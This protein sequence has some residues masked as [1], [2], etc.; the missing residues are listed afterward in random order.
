MSKYVFTSLILLPSILLGGILE[1]EVK[2]SL[3]EAGFRKIEGYDAIVLP[4]HGTTSTIGAPELPRAALHLSLPPGATVTAVEIL[5]CESEMLPGT[6]DV[7]PAQPLIPTSHVELYHK[8]VPQDPTIYSSS[9]PYPDRIIECAGTGTMSGYRIAGLLVHPFQYVP[10]EGKLVFHR[11]IRFRVSYNTDTGNAKRL[12]LKKI[13]LFL[14]DVRSLVINPDD[15]ESFKPPARRPGEKAY[16]STSL[17]PG[18]WDYVIIAASAA[19]SGVLDPVRAWKHKK[20]V[21]AKTVLRDFIYANYSGTN[22]AKVKSFVADAEATW[23][24]SWF[25]VAG[26]VDVIPIKK[27]STGGSIQGEPIPSDHYYAD[28]DPLAGTQPDYEDVWLSRASIETLKECSTFVKKTLGYEKNPSFGYTQTLAYFPSCTLASTNLGHSADTIA[29]ITPSP[30]WLD[31]IRQEW[32]GYLS[33]SEI[34]QAFN[35][36]IYFCHISAHGG[37]E[38]WGHSQVCGKHLIANVDALTN[39]PNLFILNAMCCFIGCLD[40]GSGDC[41]TEHMANNPN[42]G[43]AGIIGN[44]RYGWTGRYGYMEIGSEGFNAEFYRRLCQHDVYNF[45]KT[46]G[47]ARNSKVVTARSENYTE[48]CLYDHVPL[49]DPEMPMWSKEP[50]SLQVTHADDILPAAQ[51]FAVEVKDGGS[52]PLSQARVCLMNDS[53]YE[54]GYTNASGQLSLSVF[55]PEPGTL[56]VT[57]TAHNFIPYEGYAVIQ[58][59]GVEFDSNSPKAFDI[60]LHPNPCI[61]QLMIRY[62][63]P[64]TAHMVLSVY[65][66]TG[67]LVETL[68]NSRESM[69]YHNVAWDARTAGTGIYFCK[70]ETDDFTQVRK[71]LVVER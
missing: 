54:R 63:L 61:G 27:L 66:V 28:T 1:K 25:L 50:A 71:F 8:F 7:F 41:Y 19:D 21:R 51:N 18:D 15:V 3:N 10:S 52:S 13:E 26:D 32:H 38:G 17:P 69:G 48:Y 67:R 46:E 16:S 64:I 6:Y 30:Q 40:T 57:V 37:P 33:T 55:P 2:F 65:D 12:P 35:S 31:N 59:S 43:T 14:P 44:S 62:Q 4:G 53:V 20:G 56:W 39:F 70:M 68:L 49:G 36:G 24:A 58:E 23:G 22:Q 34:Q 47:M 60:T 11:S 5:A 45:A 29:K 42:G 9:A